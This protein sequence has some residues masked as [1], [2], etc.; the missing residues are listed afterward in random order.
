MSQSKPSAAPVVAITAPKDRVSTAPTMLAIEQNPET[1]MKSIE[2][3]SS[4][5]TSTTQSYEERMRAIRASFTNPDPLLS[6][7][8]FFNAQNRINR[9]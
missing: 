1:K 8:S 2:F 7:F 4:P 6:D 3:G 5:V 9:Y